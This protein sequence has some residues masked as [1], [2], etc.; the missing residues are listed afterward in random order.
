MPV[1]GSAR[2]TVA[3]RS[4]LVARTVVG[5]PRAVRLAG[6]GDQIRFV[7]TGTP[8]EA[9]VG[10]ALRAGRVRLRDDMSETSLR[11]LRAGVS[12]LSARV[13]ALAV[14]D[15]DDIA[16]DDA[17]THGRPPARSSGIYRC[18]RTVIQLAQNKAAR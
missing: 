18:P 9:T 13:E 3:L 5:V 16:V 10:A 11:M 17:F 14:R 8:T 2:E 6:L 1:H 12:D 4:L 15:G 7:A